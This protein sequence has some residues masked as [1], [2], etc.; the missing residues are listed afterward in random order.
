MTN[1]NLVVDLSCIRFAA[2]THVN[3]KI[4]SSII[5]NLREFSQNQSR[6]TKCKLYNFL[7]FAKNIENFL[8]ERHA[9]MM[10]TAFIYILHLQL[11]NKSIMYRR[12]CL[13]CHSCRCMSALRV[14]VR[15]CGDDDHTFQMPLDIMV[16]TNYVRPKLDGTRTLNTRN[17]TY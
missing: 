5:P 15:V 17:E 7:F 11:H 3:M 2:V 8:R 1:L 13:L 12:W 4:K 14:C 6:D 10:E 9:V 16:L